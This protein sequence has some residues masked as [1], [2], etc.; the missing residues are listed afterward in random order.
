MEYISNKLE[1]SKMFETITVGLIH[2]IYIRSGVVREVWPLYRRFP[3]DL[4]WLV[5]CYS[6]FS[7][8]RV[9]SFSFLFPSFSTVRLY[10]LHFL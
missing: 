3:D 9:K 4:H 7:V 10:S 8:C 2:K 5:V 1:E 6:V